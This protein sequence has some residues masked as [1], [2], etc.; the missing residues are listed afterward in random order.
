MST[1]IL[2][3]MTLALLAPVC[4]SAIADSSAQ[5]NR[6]TTADEPTA[7]NASGFVQAVQ[8]NSSNSMHPNATSAVGQFAD[9]DA[10]GYIRTVGR[11]SSNSMHPKA[12]VPAEPFAGDDI[13]APTANWR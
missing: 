12:P 5:Q 9:D 13:K 10:F 8:R 3:A 1:T 4:L 7:D 6:S 11:N 2:S